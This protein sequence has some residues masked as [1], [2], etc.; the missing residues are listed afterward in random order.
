MPPEGEWPKHTDSLP[1]SSLTDE[2]AKKIEEGNG[3]DTVWVPDGRPKQ[4]V[5]TH[6]GVQEGDIMEFFIEKEDGTLTKFEHLPREDGT[7]VWGWAYYN[8]TE[9]SESEGYDILRSI[10][11]ERF[12]RC[13]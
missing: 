1:T 3:I 10:V 5:G 11:E 2:Q 12:S 4:V 8:P 6:T 9:P 13:E 7:G